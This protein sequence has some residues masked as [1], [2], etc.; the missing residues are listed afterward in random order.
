M[1]VIPG[2]PDPDNLSGTPENDTINGFGGND[3]LTGL[4]GDDQLFGGGGNDRLDGSEGEDTM[5]GNAGNDTL[6]ANG[7][8]SYLYGGADDDS[9]FL[10]PIIG[11]GTQAQGYGGT[12]ND[13]IQVTG[14]LGAVAHGGDG[15]D[16]LA[17]TSYL[18]GQ[19][20]MATAI[21]LSNGS[22]TATGTGGT[23]LTFSG[24]ERLYFVGVDGADT[25]TGGAIDD[26]IYGGRGANELNG[27]AG[28][29]RMS[30]DYG[31]QQTLDGGTGDDLLIIINA[32]MPVYFIYD[33]FDGSVDDGQL[34]VITGFE[35]Y[36][37][38]G[39]TLADVISTGEG[40]D[41]ISGF[42]GDDILSGWND[43]DT[44]SGGA[45]NDIVNGDEGD[46]RLGGGGGRDTL[47]GGAGA[48][49]LLG[50]KDN[51]AL[52]G[53]A[54]NDTLIGGTGAD[55]LRGD[56][57]ADTFRFDTALEGA[58]AEDTIA[59]F[60]TGTDRLV[61][62]QDILNAA[63]SAGQMTAGDLS[64]GA[65]NGTNAQFLYLVSSSIGLL[66]WDPDGTGAAESALI[67]KF[68]DAPAL[69]GTDIYIV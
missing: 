38:E 37:I 26:T 62:L 23:S 43:A 60:V 36:E 27:G 42:G 16:T 13:L 19:F 58:A 18:S 25:V 49:R 1:P 50:G 34:S 65:L 21:D 5:Y 30:A 6:T 29:D 52:L 10:G 17:Y 54:G 3:T 2:S 15:T 67:T 12:G 41:L 64:F 45:G 7:Q 9:I 35:R 46:D 32:V 14:S 61:I 51:D 40:A 57:D 48:D 63:P 66:Y 39:S 8:L 55:L 33:S 56:A 20:D 59:D 22:G 53:G 68:L 4:G 31:A 69:A 47:Y 28:D 24:F 44:I 11:D